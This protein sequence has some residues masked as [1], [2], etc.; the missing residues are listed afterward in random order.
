MWRAVPP[1]KCYFCSKETQD[2]LHKVEIDGIVID[3][4][5]HKLT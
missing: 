4:K 5:P 1:V 3:L 2:I